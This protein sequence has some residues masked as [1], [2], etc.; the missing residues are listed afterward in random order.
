MF[1]GKIGV[2]I[3]TRARYILN[4]SGVTE[5]LARL[6]SKTTQLKELQG[7]IFEN[8][9]G[10]LHLNG[11]GEVAFT[12]GGTV[13]DNETDFL[14]VGVTVKRLI[15]LLQC[16]RHYRKLILRHPARRELGK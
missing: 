4:T 8:Q 16:A 1:K 9:S 12:V 7:P 11:L 14:K 5:P 15:G 3:S 13:F 2:G 6:I 10:Q